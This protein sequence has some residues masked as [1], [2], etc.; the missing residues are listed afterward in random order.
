[1][2][3]IEDVRNPDCQFVLRLSNAV[4]DKYFDAEFESETNSLTETRSCKYLHWQLSEL[5]VP[6]PLS[7]DDDDAPLAVEG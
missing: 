5:N 3:Q 1:M 4:L 6:K 7:Q 2:D